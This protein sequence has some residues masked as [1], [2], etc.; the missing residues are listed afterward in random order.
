MARML[1]STRVPY[2]RECRNA[3]RGCRCYMFPES[4]G[5]RAG[6]HRRRNRAAENRDWHAEMAPIRSGTAH[7][8]QSC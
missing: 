5:R 3:R 8:T 4:Y 7:H 6:Q 1:Y 2:R